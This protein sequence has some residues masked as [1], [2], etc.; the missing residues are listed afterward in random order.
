[1]PLLDIVLI[2]VLA[3]FAGV[4]VAALNSASPSGLWLFKP[5]SCRTCMSG[6]GAIGAAG[7]LLAMQ[8]LPGLQP[9]QAAFL[10]P[11]LLPD[12]ILWAVLAFAGTGGA[13]LILGL[14]EGSADPIMPD[15]SDGSDVDTAG[16]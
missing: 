5:F 15:F 14:A 10:A 4:G 16:D 13:H 6:W 7:I 3:A 2:T 8:G 11:T 9:T 12:L 1:M